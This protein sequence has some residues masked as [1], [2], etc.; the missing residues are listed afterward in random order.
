MHPLSD[1]EGRPVDDTGRDG[2]TGPGTG[3]PAGPDG[4]RHLMAWHALRREQ[5]RTALV[6]GDR[7]HWRDRDRLWPAVAVGLAITVMALVV[8]AVGAVVDPQRGQDGVVAVP[9]VRAPAASSP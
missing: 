2:D 6:H 5:L 1:P 8:I 7:R 9:V 3:A 4:G